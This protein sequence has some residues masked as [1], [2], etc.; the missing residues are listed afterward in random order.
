M[1]RRSSSKHAAL[2]LRVST[3][4]QT[5]DNQRR[6]LEAA[7]AARGWLVGAV[8]ADEGISGAKGR[9]RRPGLDQM[10]K[11]AVRRK[12]DVVLSWSVDRLGR[13]LADLVGGLHELHAA[14]VDLYLHQQA[15]DTTTPAGK[16]IFQMAGVFAEFERSMIQ[17]RVRAGLARAQAEQAAGMVRLDK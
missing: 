15:I 17:D 7:A 14:R 8:Y 4:G 11:D 10:L 9:D 12:F 2:Y 16:V 5:V 3:N 13:S 6:E 1:A